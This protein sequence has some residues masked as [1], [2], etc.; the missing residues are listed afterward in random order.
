MKM[1]AV[2]FEP[3]FSGA[4]SSRVAFDKE[5][6]YSAS[7]SLDGTNLINAM[8]GSKRYSDAANSNMKY[9]VRVAMHGSSRH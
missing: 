6:Q 4:V 9:A 8:L 3:K 1:T 5:L 7:L 2:G